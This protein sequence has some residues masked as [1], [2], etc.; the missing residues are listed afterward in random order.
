MNTMEKAILP[1]TLKIGTLAL[2]DEIELTQELL[3][4]DKN[5]N[6][7]AHLKAY[8]EGFHLGKLAILTMIR[9]GLLK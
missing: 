7:N 4:N 1:R 6:H 5:A 9:D 8:L 2:L 3:E